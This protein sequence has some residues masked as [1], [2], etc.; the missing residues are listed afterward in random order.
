MT[1]LHPSLHISARLMAAAKIGDATVHVGDKYPD[2]RGRPAW[3]YIIEHND[4]RVLAEGWDLRGPTD[5]NAAMETLLSF[6]DAYAEAG[7]EGENAD[8][9]P[10]SLRAWAVENAD[11]IGMLQYELSEEE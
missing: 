11:E 4:G 8:L 5:H 1:T 7:P 3:H 10:V 9:F 2:T 6:I